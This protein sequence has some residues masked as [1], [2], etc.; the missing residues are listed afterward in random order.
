MSHEIIKCLTDTD[1]PSLFVCGLQQECV[2]K[3]IFPPTTVEI[4]A[5][6]VMCIFNS[7][8]SA[9]GVAEAGLLSSYLMIFM[10]YT[11]EQSISCASAVGLGGALGNFVNVVFLKHPDTKKPFVNY[12]ICLI[13]IPMLMAGVFVGVNI[14]KV[15]PN[16]M[17]IIL[18]M[19]VLLV[20]TY[21]FIFNLMKQRRREEELGNRLLADT[22]GETSNGDISVH[23]VLVKTDREE[24]DPQAEEKEEEEMKEFLKEEQRLI[25]FEKY[26][27][28]FIMIFAIVVLVLLRG[29]KATPSLIEIPYCGLKYWIFLLVI[30]LFFVLM[31]WRTSR[32]VQS[33]QNKRV[34]MGLKYSNELHLSKD[35]ILTIGGLAGCA[36]II[37]ASISIGGGMIMQPF[38]LHWGLPP[39]DTSYTCAFFIIF[40]LFNTTYQ[41][42]LAGAL[43]LHQIAWF[44]G[45]AFVCSFLSSKIVGAYIRK[46]GKQSVL[47][48]LLVIVSAI[49]IVMEVYVTIDEVKHDYA[50]LIAWKDICA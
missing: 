1:C 28:V 15:V 13:I 8:G 41:Q 20:S 11:L 4:I 5:T 40:T 34:E 26:R 17:T 48:Q 2:H 16:Y 19:I 36:G 49:S 45:I 33:W 30:L 31:F 7:L 47:L 21:K 10:K 35:R 6:I 3:D 42:L 24:Y 44:G 23:K 50:K 37:G 43:N 38:F 46:T 29:S 22:K 32:L 9:A 39:R 12:D 25:P 18:L 14:P 27:E